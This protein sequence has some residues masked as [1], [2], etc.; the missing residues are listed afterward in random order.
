MKS[1]RKAYRSLPRTIHHEWE[2]R[3]YRSGVHWSLYISEYDSPSWHKWVNVL[4]NDWVERA[5]F[6]AINTE[7]YIRV[8]RQFILGC[9]SQSPPRYDGQIVWPTTKHIAVVLCVQNEDETLTALLEQLRLL[10]FH[11]TILVINGST[12][13]SYD[14]A[15]AHPTAQIVF[16]R[17]ALGHDV[18]RAIGAQ[19]SRSD[20]VLFLD[21]DMVVAAKHLLPFLYAFE[22]KYD[23]VLNDIS[24][25]LGTFATWDSVTTLKQFLNIALMRPELKMNS[26]TAIPHLLSKEA[27][28][29]IGAAHLA[30]PPVA[31]AIA[32]QSE[33]RIGKVR[34]PNVIATNKVRVQNNGAKNL[35]AEL[36]IGDHV[37]ALTTQMK[38]R[39]DRLVFVDLIRDRTCYEPSENK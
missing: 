35:V 3:A 4:W 24:P 6:K 39:G 30:V 27:I 1:R 36:I 15:R 38:T 5:D 12:D 33:L 10:P 2:R 13:N 29:T 32:I 7:Q 16:Y 26:L 37:E 11:E 9:L 18:G 19:R 8:G 20:A 28:C 17:E 22:Q 31:Q 34:G 21:A 23:I 14:I 25:H